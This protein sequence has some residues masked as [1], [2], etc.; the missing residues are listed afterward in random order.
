M[1]FNSEIYDWRIVGLHEMGHVLG[2][3]PIW[4]HFRFLQDYSR[5][6]RNRDKHFNGPLAIAA[7]DDAGGRDYT[8]AKVPVVDGGHWRRPVLHGEL[9]SSGGGSALSAITVQSL[10]DL[11]YGVD[12]SQADAYTLPGAS[13][14]ETSGN[15]A[16]TAARAMP[17]ATIRED[18][19][20]RGSLASPVHAELKL[21][22][23]L[24][25]EREPIHA[26]D[27]QG[28]IILTIGN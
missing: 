19:R 13:T 2:F 20:L 10:A 26:V 9:M 17:A 14:T 1:S 8:G 21:W 3:G 28:R 7:F 12:V 5:D 11:G 23:G 27:Q 24:G 15:D 16:A 18:D 25:G 4:H 22:C 6:N